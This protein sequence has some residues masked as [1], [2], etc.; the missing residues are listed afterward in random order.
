[1]KI[2]LLFGP[3]CLGNGENGYDFKRLY[4]DSRGLS[5]SDYGYFRIAQELAKR[6]HEIDLYTFPK[7]GT[8]MPSEFSPGVRLHHYSERTSYRGDVAVS[9]NESEPLLEMDPNLLKVVSLQINTLVS[10][11]AAI[12]CVDL[13]L[14]PSESHRN[15]IL[16]GTWDQFYDWEDDDRYRN[17]N[18]VRSHKVGNF[19]TPDDY[20]PNPDQWEIVPDGCDPQVYDTL[21]KMGHQKVP[22]RCIWSSSPDRGLHWLLSIWPAVKAAVPHASLR[23]FY[24]L[25]PWIEHML[26]QS[27]IE[28]DLSI[29]EQIRRAQYIDNAL[30]SFGPEMDVEVFDSVSRRRIVE[31]Q[32]AAEVFPY[33][34]DTPHIWSEGY[35]CS[36]MEC[37][38]AFACPITT[39][40]DALPEVYGGTLPIIPLPLSE[41]IGLFR[42]QLIQALTDEKARAHANEKARALAE[43]NTWE[44]AAIRMEE[45]LWNR[46]TNW[47]HVE[48]H[49]KSRYLSSVATM[50]RSP[51]E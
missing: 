48:H 28:G 33:T 7:P 20:H 16:G 9:W 42:D 10:S 5:G 13:W 18:S 31:E 6:G 19:W 47:S 36:L 25:K 49:K 37:C 11:T 23:I 50:L 44:L 12:N 2:C 32:V 4:T 43:R 30:R 38:A 15:M 29:R 8:E 46:L 45:I 3:F 17:E 40:C 26:N 27:P 35:S 34:C 22:G 41:S 39:S 51:L 1:M 24:R 21:F 14:S